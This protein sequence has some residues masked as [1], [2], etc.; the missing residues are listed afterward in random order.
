MI[1]KR[2]VVSLLLQSLLLTANLSYAQSD[3]DFARSLYRGGEN[4]LSS[5]EIRRW[6]HGNQDD[7][8][9]PFAQYLLALCYGRLGRYTEAVAT[10]ND[11]IDSI[12]ASGG[13]SIYDALF[14][15]SHLQLMNLHFRER[16]FGD[17]MLERER[18]EASCF[19]ADPVLASAAQRMAVAVHVYNRNW[20]EALIALGSVYDLDSGTAQQIEREIEDMNQHSSK[21]PVLGGIYALIPGGGHLY[22]GMAIA[23]LRSFFINA[24][25]IG[26]SVFCFVMGLPVLGALF[27]VIEGVLYFSNIY[28]GVN[29]VIRRNAVFIVETRDRILKLLVIPP[30]DAI[31]FREVL[32]GS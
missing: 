28:G 19:E 4:E 8:F 16:R 24:A 22:A 2:L 31:T 9:A 25:C 3:I 1:V 11:L 18:F 15:E 32:L 10:L 6:L 13:E 7:A 27:A 23:G 29:A 12:P 21:S 26:I 5:L 17:F 14:C 30:V 20:D